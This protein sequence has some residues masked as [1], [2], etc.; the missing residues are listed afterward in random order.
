[1]LVYSEDFAAGDWLLFGGASRTGNNI[2]VAPDGTTTADGVRVTTAGTGS[3]IYQQQIFT[4]TA[5]PYTFSC[6]VKRNAASDQTF[7]LFNNLQGVQVSSGNLTATDTWQRFS[8]T[9]TSAAGS[10]A[11]LVG[12]IGNTS[13]AQADLLVWGAQLELGSTATAY[14]RVTTQYDVTEAGV[15]SLSYL[16]FDGVDDF[17]VTPTITPGVD[18]A[19]VFAG[20]RKLSDAVTGHIVGGN[21]NNTG[22]FEILSGGWS[23]SANRYGAGLFTNVLSQID[24]PPNF[25]PPRTDVLSW[26]FDT[27]GATG[28]DK[29]KLNVNSASQTLSIAGLPSA[30]NFGAFAH[31]IGRR[32]G[33]SLPFNG[34]IYNL[35]VRFGA[36]LDAG[37]IT[38]TETFVN[39]KTGAF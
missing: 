33:T 8:H 9:S 19:Q 28:P 5:V 4:A 31:H 1:L 12:I 23:V 22:Q 10:G 18:K 24:S 2:G 14:Q 16:S 26:R 34:Q 20:V 11:M 36:N 37:T 38:S 21:G 27:S 7:Q 30:A 39:Q 6:Y 13:G 35:I 25:T 32:E 15:Q 3:N 29:A 17:L